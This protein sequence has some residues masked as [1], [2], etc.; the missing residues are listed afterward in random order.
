[1]SNHPD[2][3]VSQSPLRLVVP[4]VVTA[5]NIVCGFLA[6]LAAA[7]ARYEL[8][9]YLLLIA[10]NFDML[11]GFVARLLGATSEFG[12]QMDSFSDALSFGVAPAFLVYRACLDGHGPLAVVA[13]LV[14]IVAA[15]MRLS[16]FNLTTNAHDKETKTNGVPVPIAAGYL[17][18]AVLM[19]DRL[20]WGAVVL[21]VLTF[22]ALMPS[23]LRLPNLKGRNVVSLMLLVG[24]VNY[25]AVVFFPGWTTVIWWNVWNVIILVV[26]HSQDRRMALEPVGPDVT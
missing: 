9:V 8:S 14:Y 21:V 13:V 25:Y 11:D 16:R 20:P 1:M 24:V 26:A 18:V 23:H 7:D 3:D 22:A 19:R 12:R 15:V 10:L 6:M 2:D 4:S 17:M 5:A